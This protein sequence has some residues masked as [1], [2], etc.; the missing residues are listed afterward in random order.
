MTS[1]MS[2]GHYLTFLSLPQ[3]PWGSP[4]PSWGSPHPA[5]SPGP[6]FNPLGLWIPAPVMPQ[7]G[8]STAPHSPAQPGRGPIPMEVT[9]SGG[10]GWSCLCPGYPGQGG[11]TGPVCQALPCH[12]GISPRPSLHPDSHAIK[13]PVLF[14]ESCQ[15]I[16]SHLCHSVWH[17]ALQRKDKRPKGQA[18]R[19]L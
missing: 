6:H 1:S 13:L 17:S 4:L 19:L 7:Q 11:G 5:Q 8:P 9:H 16:T 14:P 3:L 12:S 10:W 15:G 2:W 18:Y